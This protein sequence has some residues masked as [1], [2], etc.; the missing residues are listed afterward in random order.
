MYSLKMFP[1]VRFV[2]TCYSTDNVTLILQTIKFMYDVFFV[3]VVKHC[4]TYYY[5]DTC[6]LSDTGLNKD[7]QV[8]VSP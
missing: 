5:C 1:H 3:R 6:H 7:C 4:A 2:L 8:F